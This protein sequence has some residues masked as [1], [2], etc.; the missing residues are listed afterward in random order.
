MNLILVSSILITLSA[1]AQVGFNPNG[2]PAY[3]PAGSTV[4]YHT[5]AQIWIQP[6]SGIYSVSLTADTTLPGVK[7]DPVKFGA[8]LWG[9]TNV[10]LT[11]TIH[12]DTP[13]CYEYWGI[14]FS[15]SVQSS[16]GT[17][18]GGAFYTFGPV[19][20]YNPRVIGH[21]QALNMTNTSNIVSFQNT[22][23]GTS[24]ESQFHVVVDSPLARYRAFTALNLNPPFHLVD[25]IPLDYGCQTHIISTVK[26]L[27][28]RAGTFEDTAYIVDPLSNDSLPLILAGTA[29]EAAVASI[30][31]S[32]EIRVSPNPA[33]S[34]IQVLGAQRS[35]IHIY[36]L[37]GREVMDTKEVA[38]GMLNISSLPIGTYMLQ[39]GTQT[40]MLIIAR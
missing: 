4:T 11:I 18:T 39:A 10:S 17:T 2:G 1:R 9:T 27:P 12:S 5:V 32:G 28:D 40:R 36:D 20:F 29:Y 3:A 21:T 24:S 7:V 25:S 13:E 22:A 6:R 34:E 23:V 16:Q 38:D 19:V 35:F 8:D 30:Q 37:L 31:K 15:G 14:G 26:F 33:S